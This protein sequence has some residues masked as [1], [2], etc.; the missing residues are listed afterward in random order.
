VKVSDTLDDVAIGQIHIS[1]QNSSGVRV[2]AISGP[3]AFVMNKAG[4]VESEWPEEGSSGRMRDW[5]FSF[6]TQRDGA[7]EKR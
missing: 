1:R 7:V 6:R 2:H 5:R 3:M 4:E